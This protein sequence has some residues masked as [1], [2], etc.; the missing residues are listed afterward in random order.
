MKI[1]VIT[2]W[3]TTD[4]YG[5]Q[6]Q[7]YALQ[8]H[9]RK[10]GH[11][12]YLIRYESSYEEK[13]QKFNLSVLRQKVGLLLRYV[14]KRRKALYEE[15][16]RERCLR[17]YNAEQNP[18]RRFTAFR[19]EYL[20]LSKLYYSYQQ[21]RE[22]PPE[23]DVYIVGSDQVWNPLLD[24]SNIGVWYLQFGRKQVRRI[25]YA[26]SFGRN[27]SDAEKNRLSKLLQ[28]LDAI[29]VREENVQ[30]TLQSMGLEDVELVVDPTLLV[31][32][33]V[34][35]KFIKKTDIDNPYIFIYYLNI[36]TA[37]ELSWDQIKEFASEHDYGIKAVTA[38]GYYPAREVIPGH[39]TLYLTIPEWVEALYNAS[40][41]IT[42]SF[43]GIAMA[44]VMH[45]PFVAILLGKALKGGNHRVLS[46]LRLL[47]LEERILT[48]ENSI[49]QIL[50]KPIDWMNVDRLMELERKRSNRFLINAL[51]MK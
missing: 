40:Y 10:M 11:D 22:D 3:R 47:H 5:Q 46:L 42:T 9:L 32:K 45:R 26:A 8:Q 21:L 50:S 19:E 18:L 25:S 41:V 1:G 15:M 17:Q 27:I 33:D 7:V 37:D 30:A 35:L 34:Y 38:S 43:H 14:S 49:S 6:L 29:S 39:S 16:Q 4:N 44:I 12:A 2:H 48:C 28:G 51:N 13:K 20:Q 36:K 24:S 31:S 23:A